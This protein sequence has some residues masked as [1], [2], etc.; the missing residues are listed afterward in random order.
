MEKTSPVKKSLRRSAGKPNNKPSP[1]VD[2]LFHSVHG[3]TLR[4]KGTPNQGASGNSTRTAVVAKSTLE[5]S[6]RYCLAHEIKKHHHLD[7]NQIT[8]RMMI[9][10]WIYRLF[11]FKI[12]TKNAF[13]HVLSI[14][15]VR[16]ICVQTKRGNNL[17]TRTWFFQGMNVVRKQN[18]FSKP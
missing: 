1:K 9:N 3:T 17:R 15:W 16:N 10:Q 6:W 14:F 4:W 8:G 5:F 12:I 7:D 11:T 18:L 2:S 13:L